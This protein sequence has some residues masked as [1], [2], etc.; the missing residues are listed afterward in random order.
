M[1]G[2]LPTLAGGADRLLVR[3]ARPG[4]ALEVAPGRPLALERLTDGVFTFFAE[5]IHL[6]EADSPRRPNLRFTS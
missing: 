1:R 6:M 3:I 4:C 5:R 2:R